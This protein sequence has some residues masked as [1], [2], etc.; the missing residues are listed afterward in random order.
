MY[1][2]FVSNIV[3][4]ALFFL[5]GAFRLV[6]R[7]LKVNEI[8]MFLCVCTLICTLQIYMYRISHQRS[9]ILVSLD[10]IMLG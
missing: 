3:F 10:E 1:V 9:K 5:L 8:F 7:L 2:Q 6:C 4:V